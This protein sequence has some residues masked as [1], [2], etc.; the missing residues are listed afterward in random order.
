MSATMSETRVVKTLIMGKV[1][2]ISTQRSDKSRKA[3][4][5][6]QYRRA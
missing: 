5:D 4:S 2:L 1:R 6:H 3:M